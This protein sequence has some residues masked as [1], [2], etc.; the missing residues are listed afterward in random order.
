MR[1][2]LLHVAQGNPGVE[3]GGYERMSERVRRC[4][5]IDGHKPG[6]L[7]GQ[8]YRPGPLRIQRTDAV[9]AGQVLAGGRR[10]DHRAG[11]AGPARQRGEHQQPPG[12]AGRQLLGMAGRHSPG[13]PGR[14]S[15]PAR[16]RGLWPAIDDVVAVLTAADTRADDHRGGLSQRRRVTAQ[17]AGQVDRAAA[18]VRVGG[19]PSRQVAQRLPDAERGHRRGQHPGHTGDRRGIRGGDQYLSGRAGRHQPVQVRRIAKV[20]EHHQP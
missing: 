8:Q 17:L 20:I 9:L 10:G 7:Q 18:L 16:T 6:L 11:D 19:Q 2:R 1:G 3:R 5:R 13:Q 14:R 15:R 12:A 4:R